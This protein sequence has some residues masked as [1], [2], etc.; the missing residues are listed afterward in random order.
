MNFVITIVICFTIY[1]VVEEIC[2]YL[3]Y[4]ED[5]ENKETE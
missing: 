4:K 3:K 1:A 5:K 2:D